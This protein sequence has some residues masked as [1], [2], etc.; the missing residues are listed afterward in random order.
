MAKKV[1][2]IAHKKSH[3]NKSS[4][5]VSHTP[6][7]TF[8]RITVFY[9]FAALVIVFTLLSLNR[10]SF[11]QS[12]AGASIFRPLYSQSVVYWSPIPGAV[13]YN[14]YYKTN[15]EPTFSNA[16][17]NIPHNITAYTIS[18]LKKNVQY[19]YKVS[20]IAPSGEEF[21][22]SNVFPLLNVSPM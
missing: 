3:L 21:W 1:K 17:R 8:S 9:A 15:S 6:V 4:R 2:K 12:V 16:V 13:A 22:F 11:S 18:Y 20:A 5:S 14:I 7:Y 10:H 19:Q